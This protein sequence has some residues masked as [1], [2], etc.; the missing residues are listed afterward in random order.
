MVH[1]R[2]ENVDM[3]NNKGA[4]NV[5]KGKYKKSKYYFETVDWMYNTKHMIKLFN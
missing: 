1:S 2:C 4:E 3:K 5:S